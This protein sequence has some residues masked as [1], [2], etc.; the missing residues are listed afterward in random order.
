MVIRQRS[1]FEFVIHTEREDYLKVLVFKFK[2][3]KGGHGKSSNV[4]PLVI[5]L[6]IE[7]DEALEAVRI[8]LYQGANINVQTR[9]GETAVIVAGWIREDLNLVTHLVGRGADVNIANENGDTPLIDAAYKGNIDIL[10]YLLNN[11]A[12]I[13]VENKNGHCCIICST[14]QKEFGGYKNDTQAQGIRVNQS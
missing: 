11:G 6:P 13:N 1:L 4:L 3:F 14:V 9:S 12:D 8:L 5:A 2:H 10:E 7:N